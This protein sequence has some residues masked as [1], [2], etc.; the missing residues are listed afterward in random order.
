VAGQI[1]IL[2]GGKVPRGGKMGPNHNDGVVG[3]IILGHGPCV[4]SKVQ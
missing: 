3:V 2:E 4:T 1:I